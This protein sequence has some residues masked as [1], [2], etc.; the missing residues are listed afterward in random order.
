[1]SSASGSGSGSASGVDWP[2]VFQRYGFDTPDAAGNWGASPTQLRSILDAEGAGWGDVES[3]I[4]EGVLEEVER[5]RE[6]SPGSEEF[7]KKT[8]AYRCYQIEVQE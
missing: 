2:E 4:E 6:T 3:A 5:R 8:T 1:M 7:L